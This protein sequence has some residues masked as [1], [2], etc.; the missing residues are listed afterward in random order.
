MGSAH[1]VSWQWISLAPSREERNTADRVPLGGHHDA[2]E[3][4]LRSELVSRE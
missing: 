2:A 1:R 4:Q 3:R